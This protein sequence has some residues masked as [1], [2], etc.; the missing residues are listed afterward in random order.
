MLVLYAAYY[1]V[2]AACWAAGKLLGDLLHFFWDKPHNGDHIKNVCLI[3]QISLGN[4]CSDQKCILWM[5]CPTLVSPIKFVGLELVT[6]LLDLFCR[7]QAG[8]M[9]LQ[10]P[11]PQ[12]YPSPSTGLQGWSPLLPS[13]SIRL[14]LDFARLHCSA[15]WGPRGRINTTTRTWAPCSSINI[16]GTGS[17]LYELINV[18]SLSSRKKIIF[19]RIFCYLDEWITAFGLLC[20][21]VVKVMIQILSPEHWG[22]YH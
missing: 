10:P 17:F 15:D 16:A 1:Q 18:A 12:R 22:K 6:V 4:S 19:V 14:D 20:R 8:V 2:G 11:P 9:E 5:N 7:N 21:G 13:S 3:M